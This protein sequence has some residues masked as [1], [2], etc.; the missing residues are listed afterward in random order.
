[1]SAS[2]EALLEGIVT[3]EKEIKRVE[4]SGFDASELRKA[5]NELN[6]R[7]ASA[8]QALNEGKGVL[9]G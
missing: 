6:Q 3:L 4:E 1:M 7:L 8:N 2:T 9:K 5:L